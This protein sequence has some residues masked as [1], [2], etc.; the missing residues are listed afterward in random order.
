[1]VAVSIIVLIGSSFCLGWSVCERINQKALDEAIKEIAHR[2]ADEICK[3]AQRIRELEKK[4][5]EEE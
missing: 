4:G 3:M 1:M 2:H 5:G